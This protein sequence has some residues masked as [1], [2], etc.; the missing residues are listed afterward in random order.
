MTTLFCTLLYL[1]P[2]LKEEFV[3]AFLPESGI[4]FYWAISR[5]NLNRLA[6]IN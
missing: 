3:N 1:L 2:I 4:L 6:V 5:I